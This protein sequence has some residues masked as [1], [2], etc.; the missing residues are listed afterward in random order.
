MCIQNHETGIHEH[1]LGY[2]SSYMHMYMYIYSTRLH[3]PNAQ[4]L[5]CTVCTLMDPCNENTK[6][7]HG[8]HSYMC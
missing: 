8:K 1:F 3:T 2:G 7:L 5:H 4:S 6:M